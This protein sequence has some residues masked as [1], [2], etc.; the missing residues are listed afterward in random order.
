MKRIQNSKKSIFFLS[1]L[2]FFFFSLH[3]Y[4]LHWL[5]CTPSPSLRCVFVSTKT[6]LIPIPVPFES[7]YSSHLSCYPYVQLYN[8]VSPPSHLGLF[9]S[10]WIKIL[11]FCC[12]PYNFFPSQPIS[13]S[14]PSWALFFLLFLKTFWKKNIVLWK[15]GK[16]QLFCTI[17]IITI[18]KQDHYREICIPKQP[19]QSFLCHVFSAKMCRTLW[20]SENDFLLSFIEENL[21][22]SGN[23]CW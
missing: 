10:C 9:L 14:L 20:L 17:T 21:W 19:P 22:L 18:N 15:I 11:Q 8:F 6:H 2:H 13:Q 4:F 7:L 5:H 3:T 12:F 23:D 1:A 16:S